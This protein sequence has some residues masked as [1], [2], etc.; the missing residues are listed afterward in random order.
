MSGLVIP[1]YGAAATVQ[2]TSDLLER[3]RSRILEIDPSNFWR[4]SN[5][6]L[7]P[8]MATDDPSPAL[9]E[10]QSFVGVHLTH[11]V[12]GGVVAEAT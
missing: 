3:F 10:I 6:L 5:R 12:T 7:D 1:A 4:V 8:G 2:W 9:R 11:G